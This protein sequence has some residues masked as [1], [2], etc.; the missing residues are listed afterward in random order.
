[1]PRRYWKRPSGRSDDENQELNKTL[2]SSIEDQWLA[3][4]LRGETESTERLL[5][6]NYLGTTSDGVLQTKAD[7][8]QRIAQ[9]R[10]SFTQGEHTE[11]YIRFYGDIAVSVGVAT[12]RAPDRS[13]SFR[14]LRVFQKNEGSWRLIASQST[15][16]RAI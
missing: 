15:R 12:L 8:I 10:V 9:S 2:L 3:A 16:I 11:R 5:D 7:F 1:M 13:H 6:A 4:R 14:Y